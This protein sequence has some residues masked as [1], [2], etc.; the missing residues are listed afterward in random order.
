MKKKFLFLMT[1]L[2]CVIIANA[3]PAKRG[4]QT[5]KQSDGTILTV[6]AV[7]NA[8]NHAILTDDG[9]MVARGAD[10][11]FYYYSSLTGLT[12]VRAHDKGHRTA[13]EE[14]FVSAQS[15]N[16][17]VAGKTT[18]RMNKG[19]TFKVGGSNADA[20]VPAQGQRKIP[21]I[22]VQFKDKYF[23]NTREA[24]INAMLMG[25]S[26]VGQYFRDQSNGLYQPDF[27]VYGIYTLSQ[28]R[29]YYGGHSGNDSDKGLGYLVTE[30]CQKASADGASFKP[31]DTNN[32]DYCDVV[33][34]IYAGVGEAQAW[35]NHPEAIWPCNWNLSSAAYYGQGGNGAFRP[36]Y[37]DPLVNN[38]AVFNE[39]NGSN[40]DATTI[41]GIGTF[42]HEFGH[43][44]G[45]PDFYDTSNDNV[46]HHGM[47]SWD[48][49]CN[50]C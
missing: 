30:A 50:G 10:G 32:D 33:I 43:C 35:W 42:A 34:V 49:M 9:L 22:L 39:L 40:D 16:L 38:F 19:A 27:D 47:G 44:L 26:S 18:P 36:K 12:A 7:G 25:N 8:F 1:L 13:S 3:V 6:H 21:I 45:L 29:E 48:I 5:I 23:N 37:N 4:S 14:A 41:D 46:D 24:I 17:T 11:D 2:C 31:Y 20:S 15:S 28:N